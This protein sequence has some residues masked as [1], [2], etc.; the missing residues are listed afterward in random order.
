MNNTKTPLLPNT[1][2]LVAQIIFYGYRGSVAVACLCRAQQ[3]IFTE[4][5][6]RSERFILAAL[7]RL[8]QTL[9]VAANK[10]PT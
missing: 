2:T 4:G 8:S 9:D 7:C 3:N 10:T 1:F 5:L 6:K